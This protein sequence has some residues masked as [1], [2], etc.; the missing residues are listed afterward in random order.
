MG[1][2][3]FALSVEAS[4][5]NYDNL[6]TTGGL[7]II[8]VITGFFGLIAA[9]VSS[10]NKKTADVLSELQQQSLRLYRVEWQMKELTKEKDES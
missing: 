9:L 3:I 8:A 10:G 2:F 1:F 7:I 4:A 6:I 5:I